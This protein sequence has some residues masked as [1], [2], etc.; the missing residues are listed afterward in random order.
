VAVRRQ[1][2]WV[3]CDLG[4]NRIAHKTVQAGFVAFTFHTISPG[5]PETTAPIRTLTKFTNSQIYKEIYK[6]TD[7]YSRFSQSFL[8]TNN[9]DAVHLF[10]IGKVFT[11][12]V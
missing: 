5:N 3:S 7:A 1:L 6:F 11:E 8:A 10:M 4:V 12:D 2:C 9:S